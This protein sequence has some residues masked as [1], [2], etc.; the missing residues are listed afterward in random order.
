MA[1][2]SSRTVGMRPLNRAVKNVSGTQ[3]NVCHDVENLQETTLLPYDDELNN[4]YKKKRNQRGFKHKAKSKHKSKG[5]KVRVYYPY[6]VPP[7]FK[8]TIS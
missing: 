5:K 7:M 8:L 2:V 1:P 6:L 3:V 4:Y